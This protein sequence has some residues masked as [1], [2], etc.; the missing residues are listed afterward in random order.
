MHCHAFAHYIEDARTGC[1]PPCQQNRTRN[2]GFSRGTNLYSV[3]SFHCK[4]VYMVGDYFRLAK[5]ISPIM[6]EPNSQAAAGSGTALSCAI[7]Q[8]PVPAILAE[9]GVMQPGWKSR[10]LLFV[11]MPLVMRARLRGSV[12]LSL[13]MRTSPSVNGVTSPSYDNESSNVVFS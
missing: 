6:P 12:L 4:Y 3:K 13:A 8:L 7:E 9:P 10:L 1:Q 2:H 11:S 5:P